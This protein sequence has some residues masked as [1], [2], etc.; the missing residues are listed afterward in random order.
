MGRGEDEIEYV[1]IRKEG[2]MSIYDI[3]KMKLVCQSG[4]VFHNF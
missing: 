3:G 2:Y 4:N 1:I